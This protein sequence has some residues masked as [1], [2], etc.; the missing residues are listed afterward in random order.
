MS[1]TSDMYAC[2]AELRR[3]ALVELE[4]AQVN[5]IRAAG[6]QVIRNADGRPTHVLID[7]TSLEQRD[8]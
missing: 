5:A 4:S 8:V 6:F 1:L 3:K 7:V 2:M